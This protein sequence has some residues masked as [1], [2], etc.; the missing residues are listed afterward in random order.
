MDRRGDTPLARVV[1]S[2]PVL[3]PPEECIPLADVPS[4]RARFL[5]DVLQRFDIRLPA[6]T[7]WGRSPGDEPFEVTGWIRFRDGTEPSVLSLLLLV[8]AFP[9]TLIGGLEVG[10]VPTVEL[11]VHV[12]ARPVPGGLVGTFRTRFLIDGL[13]E[14]DGEMW[15]SEGR[16]VALTRQ[17]AMALPPS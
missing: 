11:T 13:L 15:D 8:D 3:P 9:P 1:A 2:R 7:R 14:E 4:D 6:D 17:L 12:R 16:L 5:P 10:W